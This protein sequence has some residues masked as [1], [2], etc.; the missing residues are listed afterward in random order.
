MNAPTTTAKSPAR[1]QA[2]ILVAIFFGPLILAFIL[3]YGAGAWRPHGSTNTGDLITPAR[4]LPEMNLAPAI[5]G[6]P[7]DL[8]SLKG[9]WTLVFVGDGQCDARCREALV[10]TRQ[11]RLALNKDI[12]RVQRLFLVTDGCCD[13]TY[14]QTEHTDL[15]T[16]LIDGQ[17]GRTLLAVFP[18]DAATPHQGRIYIVDPLGN[19][20]MSYAPDAP[21]KGLLQDMKKLLK[22]S[23]IG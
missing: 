2:W 20:M 22:L 13:R 11:T 9:K 14:L 4:P 17:T 6:A 23:H 10:L 3:Y 18:E 8:N 19:L 15:R 21:R 16:A 1:T 12:H 7:I 5:D